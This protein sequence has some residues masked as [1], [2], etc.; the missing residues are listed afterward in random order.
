MEANYKIVYYA[1][2]FINAFL[3]RV[4]LIYPTSTRRHG[5]FAGVHTLLRIL[6]SSNSAVPINIITGVLPPHFDFVVYYVLCQCLGTSS[7]CDMSII[8]YLFEFQLPMC[9]LNPEFLNF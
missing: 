9:Y 3:S 5:N 1:T 8:I 6:L 7:R 2:S 4:L